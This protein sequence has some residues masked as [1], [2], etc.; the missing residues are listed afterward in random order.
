MLFLPLPSSNRRLLANASFYL[1]SLVLLLSFFALASSTLLLEGCSSDL[2]GSSI[3]A[4]SVPASSSGQT[5]AMSAVLPTGSVG[6]AY[7]ATVT[8]TGGRAPYH[9]SL[10]SARSLDQVLE[11]SLENLARA[12]VSILQFRSPIR[13]VHPNSSRFKSRFHPAQLLACLLPLKL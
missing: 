5:L 8:V 11:P 1:R 6:V 12:E 3:P 2:S 10:P 7:S 13:A 9:F 4:N